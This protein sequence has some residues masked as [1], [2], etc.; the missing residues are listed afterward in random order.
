MEPAKKYLFL[1]GC[2]LLYSVTSLLSKYASGF[3]FL[4]G[5]YLLLL[6]LMVAVLG[7]YAILWQQAIK[8]FSP[9]V[10]Y[11]NKSVTTIWVLLFSVLILGKGSLWATSSGRRSSLREWFWWRTEM[12][13]YYIGV[14]A[15]A[16]LSAVSQLMLNISA[17]KKYK[18]KF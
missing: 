3:E 9:S 18:G 7:V 17:K 6:F 12:T 15:T 16:L 1:H 10:A 11:S 5:Q 2:I 13:K 8:G 4:S 14:V